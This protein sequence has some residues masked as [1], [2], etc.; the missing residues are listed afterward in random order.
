MLSEV[1]AP[2]SACFDCVFNALEADLLRETPREGMRQRRIGQS[3]SATLARFLREEL[4]QFTLFTVTIL[5]L[6][7]LILLGDDDGP[8]L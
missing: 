5:G 4:G 7:Q 6:G 2:K 8:H 1:P 3:P